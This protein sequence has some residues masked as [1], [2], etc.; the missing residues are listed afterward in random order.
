M[1]NYSPFDDPDEV[2]SAPFRARSTDPEQLRRAAGR[3]VDR[4]D[5]LYNA[6]TEAE[7]RLAR[8]GDEPSEGSVVRF[9]KQ[10]GPGG[11]KYSYAAIRKRGLWFITQGN[12]A[13][14]GTRSG[15]PWPRFVDFVGDSKLKLATGW[16]ELG[17]DV[18][19]ET[20]S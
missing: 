2:T 3:L 14:G 18:R 6:A 15:M 19:E 5:N 8:F 13:L 9:K 12:R 16:K 4:A 20:Q 17:P 11:T 7:A 10:Y 1:S